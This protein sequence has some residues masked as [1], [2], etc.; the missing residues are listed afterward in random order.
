MSSD[1]PFRDLFA[2]AGIEGTTDDP[3]SLP[4]LDKNGDEIKEVVLGYE[5]RGSGK[6]ITTVRDIPAEKM[7]ETL[8]FIKKTLGTGGSIDS[9]LL[10]IQGDRRAQLTRFFE[11]QGIRVRGDRE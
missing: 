1:N 5:R 11:K 3:D 6:V 4:D 8:K 7:D 2:K 10:V 9:D